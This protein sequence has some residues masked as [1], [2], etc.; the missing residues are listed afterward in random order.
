MIC[1]IADS[2]RSPRHNYRIIY[3]DQDVG[4]VTSGSFSPSLGFGIGM[5]YVKNEVLP[6]EQISLGENSISINAKVT[7][8][9]FYKN[10]SAKLGEIK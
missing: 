8:K 10:G 4:S 5:G 1:F 7:S 3:K 6:G 2:R 9:P